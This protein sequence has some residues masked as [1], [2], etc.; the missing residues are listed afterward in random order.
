MVFKMNKSN[1]FSKKIE[2]F[3]QRDLEREPITASDLIQINSIAT[4]SAG[5]EYFQQHLSYINTM[6]SRDFVYNLSAKMLDESATVKK[7]F[8]KTKLG[9]E[10]ISVWLAH[11]YCFAM[12]ESLFD[13]GRQG[14]I[15]SSCRDAIWEMTLL[16]QL[17]Q[18]SDTDLILHSLYKGF[19]ISRINV[20]VDES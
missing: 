10:E 18:T 20:P 12:T 16:S 5:K 11:G 6:V 15:S 13:L 8:S 1:P 2:Y 3:P 7:L 17:Q 14:F 19:E 9:V 4:N